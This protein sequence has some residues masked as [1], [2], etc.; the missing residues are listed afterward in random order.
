MTATPAK[1]NYASTLTKGGT[2]LGKYLVLDFPEIKTNKVES[3]N[4]AGGGVREYIPDGLYGLEDI[5]ISLIV[6]S[7]VMSTLLAEVTNKTVSSIVMTSPNDTMTFDGFITSI[8]AE[9]AD[10][11]APDVNKATVVLSPTGAIAFTLPS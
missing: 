3:T 11:T 2:A 8:K 7:G 10:A 1:S 9:G 5:T 4:H 6:A